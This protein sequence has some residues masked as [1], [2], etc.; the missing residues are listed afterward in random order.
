MFSLGS[1]EHGYAT[2][3]ATEESM[4]TECVCIPHQLE[5]NEGLNGL[6][7]TCRIQFR[8]NLWATDQPFEFEKKSLKRN[9]CFFL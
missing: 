2:V 9:E 6:P 5:R 3:R 7:S 8:A 1:D 4:E